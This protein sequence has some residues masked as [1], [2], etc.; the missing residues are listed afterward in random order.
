M[1]TDITCSVSLL[2]YEVTFCEV[3][4]YLVS[5]QPALLHGGTLLQAQDF[6]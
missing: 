2:G 1:N 5:P 3:A 6:C 4:L